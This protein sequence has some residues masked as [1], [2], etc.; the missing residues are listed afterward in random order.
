M[1]DNKNRDEM[2]TP[3][4]MVDNMNHDDI[5]GQAHFVTKNRKLLVLGF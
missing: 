4:A 3:Y 2:I 5:Q 1:V